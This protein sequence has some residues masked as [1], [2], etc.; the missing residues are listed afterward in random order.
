MQVVIQLLSGRAVWNWPVIEPYA[1][2]VVR[3]RALGRFI[4]ANI[5]GPVARAGSCRGFHYTGAAVDGVTRLY[6]VNRPTAAR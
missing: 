2:V 5:G 4:D 1:H 3:D 6:K